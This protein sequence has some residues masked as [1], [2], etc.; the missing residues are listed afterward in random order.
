MPVGSTQRL[1]VIGGDALTFPRAFR[2]AQG[3]APCLSPWERGWVWAIGGADSL[4]NNVCL[5]PT[6]ESAHLTQEEVVLTSQATQRKV[7]P[8]N[9]APAMPTAITAG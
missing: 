4:P 7:S 8:P 2:Q 5:H 6:Y 9:T 1:L 3:A